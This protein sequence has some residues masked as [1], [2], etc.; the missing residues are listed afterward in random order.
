MAHRRLGYRFEDDWSEK[1]LKDT[2]RDIE[3]AVAIPVNVAIEGE[4]RVLD[5][6]RAEK[7]LRESRLIAIS[8]CGCH[9]DHRNCSA[10]LDVCI[11]LDEDAEGMLKS[12]EYNARKAT[13][14]EALDAL[15][16]AHDAGLVPMAYT[17]AGSDKISPICNCCS[18]CCHTLS[19]LV[20]FGLAK[21][22]LTSDSISETDSD[23]CSNCG[24]CEARCQFGAR[25]M[26]DGKMHYDPDHCF[27]C[28]LCVS[29][30]STGAIRLI[31]RS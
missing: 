1:E 4:Q 18:C 15:R 23:S 19:G 17:L 5:L 13:L 24:V 9:R 29:T 22:V 27:G 2:Y 8:D 6:G 25:T 7:L 12:G 16:R 21:H 10:P 3:S 28:G 14:H 11:C 31:D 26:Q 30:C 20:R